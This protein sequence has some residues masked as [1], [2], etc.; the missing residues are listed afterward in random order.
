MSAAA[1]THNWA[2]NALALDLA[3]HLRAPERMV[4]TDMQ[5]GPAGSP[6]P[7]VYTVDKSYSCPNPTAYE[8][9]ISVAD[10]R[11]DVTAGKWQSYLRYA[12]R[13]IFAVPVGL[14]SAADVPPMCGLIQRHEKAWRLARRPTVTPPD[15]PQDAW[16]KLLIDGVNRTSPRRDHDYR[17]ELG[18]DKISK[19]L[20]QEAAKWISDAANVRRTVESAR[21]NAEEIIRG[22]RESA[23]RIRK[24][25]EAEAPALWQALLEACGLDSSA[26]CWAVRGRVS[27]IES[28][29]SGSRERQALDAVLHSMRR[30]VEQYKHIVEPAEVKQGGTR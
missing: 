25:A 28:A 12:G 17:A 18:M 23:E 11:A 9:K 24:Q 6:R 27:A 13:V 29:A 14:I 3:G 5:L 30:L 7:D 21:E 20:G 16:M 4:W 10:F 2:H 1:I 22:A 15:I 26:S 8:C 19:R